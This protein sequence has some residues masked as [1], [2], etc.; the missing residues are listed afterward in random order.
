MAK[1]SE[2]KVELTGVHLCCQ[3]CV[4]AVDAAIM[5]V[6]GVKSRCNMLGVARDAHVRR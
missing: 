3:G 2:I 5:S 1:H 4:N 6:E